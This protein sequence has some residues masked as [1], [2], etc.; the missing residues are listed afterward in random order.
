MT[1]DKWRM[2]D[3]KWQMTV[4]SQRLL[5]ATHRLLGTAHRL[6]RTKAMVSNESWLLANQTFSFYRA[7]T[8]F[9]QRMSSTRARNICPR[10][11]PYAR[12]SIQDSAAGRAL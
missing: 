3:D 7:Y 9:N 8:R 5:S 1:N 11:S 12:R 6:L 10:P 4:T 2:T